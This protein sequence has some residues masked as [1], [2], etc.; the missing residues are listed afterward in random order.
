MEDKMYR[1]AVRTDS[2]YDDIPSLAL[3]AMREDDARTVAGLSM[4]VREHALHKV[5]RFDYRAHFYRYDPEQGPADAEEAGEEN[6]ART[7][8]DCLNVSD[9]EFWYSAYLKHTAVEVLTERQPI[10]DLLAHFGLATVPSPTRSTVAVKYWDCYGSDGVTHNTHQMDVVDQRQSNGQMYI[11]LGV[12]EG[13]VDDLMSVTVEVNT[14]PLNGIDHV[15]CMHVH[16]DGDN[17]ALSLFKVGNKI[18]ARPETNVTIEHLSDGPV[19]VPD[20]LYWID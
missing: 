20:A 18:L 2:D 14:N 6:E 10:A 3:F 7:E 4:L 13:D 8:C 11:A 1:A 12:L 9:T 16:F 19:G 5:E 17:L 15:P